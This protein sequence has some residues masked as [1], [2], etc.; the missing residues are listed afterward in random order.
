MKSQKMLIIQLLRLGDLI[1][2]LKAA[3]Q[4]KAENP[5]LSISIL[6]RARFAKPL[7]F[8]L[9]TVFDE[10]I[11]L[12]T[13]DF[14][15]ESV[16]QTR[17]EL[18]NFINSIKEK[19][20]SVTVNLSF[21]KSSGYLNHLIGTQW[22]TGVSRDN[23]NKI[24]IQDKWSRFVY[25][26]VMR[27]NQN[28]FNLVD[29]FRYILGCK[30]NYLL[31]NL[32]SERKSSKIVIHPFASD[33]KKH[34]GASRWA[35]V[36][37]KLSKQYPEAHFHIVGGNADRELG[38]QI[39]N[40]PSLTNSKDNISLEINKDI[41]HVYEILTK[42]MLFIGHDSMVSHLASETLTPSVILSLGPVRYQET[43][44]YQN[45]V[46][47]L[48]PKTKCFPCT[49][50]T[51]C[52]L[53]SCHAHIPHQV[54]SAVASQLIQSQKID[55]KELQK[56]VT[57]FHLSTVNIYQSEIFDENIEYHNLL[58]E[59]QDATQV[60]QH[61]YKILWHLYFND[62]DIEIT[63]PTITNEVAKELAHH[64]EGTQYLFEVYNFGTK[65][66]NQ[67][68]QNLRAGNDN[69]S[70]LTDNINKLNDVSEL[71]KVTASNYPLLQSIIDLIH[72][73]TNSGDNTELKTILEEQLVGYHDGVH[74]LTALHSLI[75][76]TI[77]P[78]HMTHS[79][80]VKEI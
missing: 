6:S 66:A 19:D 14:I 58:N 30:H 57:P 51:D 60:F 15:R 69:H 11:Y 49:V 9:E 22:N 71:T 80:E 77:T 25:S 4:L 42:S 74:L 47:N 48:V 50:Q 65:Y 79:S 55:S 46:V 62:V 40:S 17:E 32:N 26:T 54:V 45:N 35:E 16:E 34:W 24:T 72:V 10:V 36:I 27:G 13:K 67:A 29:L 28:P 44:P 68:I 1:Q 43:T 64:L 70:A 20:Y 73:N 23:K 39:L 8:L 75:K 63:Y 7:A 18:H 56:V 31:E 33:K 5:S 21:N 61:Y 2:T 52:S 53:F 3:R 41:A 78:H 38:N 59:H 37:Y 12:E 76:K